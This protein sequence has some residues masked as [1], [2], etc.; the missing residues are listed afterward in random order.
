MN[1]Q[2]PYFLAVHVR[3]F[4]SE[5]TVVEIVKQLGGDFEIVA[6]DKFAALARQHA[7]FRN[8]FT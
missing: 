2:R 3:E 5:N 8:R 7:T 4:A 6:M 1:A